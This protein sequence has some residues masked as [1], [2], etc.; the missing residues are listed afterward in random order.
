M[1][2]VELLAPAGSRESFLEAI[3]NGANAIYLA[4]KNFNA[5]NF[6]KNFTINEIKE[7]IFYAH[8]R[9]VKIYVTVNTL[10]KDSEIKEALDFVCELY[11]ANVDAILVQDIGLIDILHKAIPDLVLHASTQMNCVCLEDAIRFKNMGISRI[12]LARECPLE[13]IKRIKENLD[14]ELEVFCHG[15]LCMSYSGNCLMS[16]LI[17]GRS[18]NR[19]KCAQSCRQEYSLLFDDLN[20][21]TLINTPKMRMK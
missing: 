18:G 16:S 14:I 20:N 10:I 9:D 7:M 2:R 8:L 19:G 15:A 6:V 21:K 1:K 12:V 13:E 4:G 11:K 17:G 5:R 3:N